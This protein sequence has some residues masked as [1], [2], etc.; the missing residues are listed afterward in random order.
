MAHARVVVKIRTTPVVRDSDAR[1][2]LVVE[3]WCG[4]SDT[5]ILLQVV[6]PSLWEVDEPNDA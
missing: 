3:G 2:M 1:T 5:P 6:D 4:D